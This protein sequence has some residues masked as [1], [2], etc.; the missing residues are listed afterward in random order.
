MACGSIG[1]FLIR[2]RRIVEQMSIAT[3]LSEIFRYL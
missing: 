3:V 2:L 1:V